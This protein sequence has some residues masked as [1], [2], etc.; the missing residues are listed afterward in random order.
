MSEL[1]VTHHTEGERGRGLEELLSRPIVAVD[2]PLRVWTLSVAE[3]VACEIESL[4]RLKRMSVNAYIVSLLDQSLRHHG[5]PSVQELAPAFV[6]YLCRKGG[7]KKPNQPGR[8]AF[9]PFAEP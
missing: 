6:E 8:S 3:T 9:D 7:R 1:K 2:L 4:A 5:R